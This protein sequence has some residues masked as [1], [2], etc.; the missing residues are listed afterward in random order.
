MSTAWGMIGMAECAKIG[1]LPCEAAYKPLKRCVELDPDHAVA[2]SCLATCCST[3][4]R[5]YPAPRSTSKRRSGSTRSLRPLTSLSPAS[6]RD[7]TTWTRPS[8]RCSSTSAYRATP[9]AAASTCRRASRR[10]RPAAARRSP[11]RKLRRSP[12]PRRARAAAARDFV[13]LSRARIARRPKPPAR[14]TAQARFNE[15]E[16]FFKQKRWDEALAAF[17]AAVEKDPEMSEAWYEIGMA[18]IMKN[19]KQP[20]VAAYGPLMRCLELNPN[21]ADAHCSL[22][23]VLLDVRKDLPRAEEH[24]RAAIELDPK[25]A[26][27]HHGL[28]GASRDEATWTRPSARC[29]SAYRATPTAAASTRRRP[30]REEEGRRPRGEARRG[31]SGAVPP[32]PVAPAPRLRATS[33]G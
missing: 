22:G 33:C 4:A 26:D 20:C 18:E 7:E 9:T 24:F 11:T 29:T 10:R 12:P 14:T 3:C 30:S 6:S 23:S 15:G 13:R 8:A 5:T 17:R 19:G 32:L 1:G 16:A 28:A 25:L 2:H 21:H 31:S 27:A